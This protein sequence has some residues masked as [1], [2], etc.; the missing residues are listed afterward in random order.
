MAISQYS[1]L[2]I[3]RYGCD[4]EVYIPQGIKVLCMRMPCDNQYIKDACV[5]EVICNVLAGRWGVIKKGNKAP[6]E[7]KNTI[8]VNYYGLLFVQVDISSYQIFLP[9]G[10]LVACV[11]FPPDYQYCADSLGLGY[12][13]KAIAMRYGIS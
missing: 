7:K 10:E 1:G 6:E 11:L 4:Y 5:L 3:R 8:S 13:C 9:C 2:S 12:I